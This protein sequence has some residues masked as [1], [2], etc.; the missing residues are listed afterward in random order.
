M[1]RPKFTV[2]IADAAFG[3]SARYIR[4]LHAYVE[5]VEE[6]LGESEEALTKSRLAQ[7]GLIEN[8]R[9][10][11]DAYVASVKV[12]RLLEQKLEAWKRY[13]EVSGPLEEPEEREAAVAALKALGEWT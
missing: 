5:S 12:N 11:R 1:D 2:E 9:A 8:V 7:L 10:S 6:N 3:P 13:V 4:E